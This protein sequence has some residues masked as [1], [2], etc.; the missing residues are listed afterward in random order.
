MNT[1]PDSLQAALGRIVMA[2][3]VVT[4]ATVAGL[5]AA[6]GHDDPDPLPGDDLPP[7]W[8]GLFCTAKLPPSRLGPDGLARD[9]GLLP[10][11]ADYPN[12]LFGGARFEFRAAQD[13]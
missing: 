5:R 7:L 3:D 9:E 2:Q 12:K 13:R 8:H 10:A 4:A 11:A 6:F 1:I